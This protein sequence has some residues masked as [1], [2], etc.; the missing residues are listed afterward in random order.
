MS[1]VQTQPPLNLQFNAINKPAKMG[2][3]KP[4]STNSRLGKRTFNLKS[5]VETVPEE[6][7]FGDNGSSVTQGRIYAHLPFP[8]LILKLTELLSLIFQMMKM[9]D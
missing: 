9:S 3:D 2:D 5:D 8:F 7:D 6:I 4:S 1:S